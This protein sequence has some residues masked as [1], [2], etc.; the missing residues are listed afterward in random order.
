MPD[1]CGLVDRLEGIG[2]GFAAA[3]VL[4]VGQGVT[5][6]QAHQGG[7][8]FE[9]QPLAIVLEV[10]AVQHEQLAVIRE[11]KFHDGACEVEPEWKRDGR[12]KEKL[13]CNG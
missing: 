9:A 2:D 8:V 4:S 1:R 7:D 10:E 6:R 3:H 5:H 13:E 11:E 12:C